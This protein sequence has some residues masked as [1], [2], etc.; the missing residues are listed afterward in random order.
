MAGDWKRR[1]H[2]DAQCDLTHDALERLLR[3]QERCAFLNAAD[4][5][6]GPRTWTVA[7]RNANSGIGFPSRC[8]E[9]DR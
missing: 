7:T 1:S 4:V 8:G 5:T 2:L 9:E 6:Q 3:H